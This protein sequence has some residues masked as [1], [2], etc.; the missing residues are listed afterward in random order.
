MPPGAREGAWRGE[1]FVG[2]ADWDV[3]ALSEG[4]S[5]PGFRF[6]VNPDLDFYGKCA[7]VNGWLSFVLNIV[8]ARESVSDPRVTRESLWLRKLFE[9]TT[10]CTSGTSEARVA[11]RHAEEGRG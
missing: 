11:D 5:L 10:A 2:T 3:R 1:E 9:T 6:R 4:V 7:K 8:W